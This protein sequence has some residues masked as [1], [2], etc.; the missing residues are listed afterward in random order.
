MSSASTDG[1]LYLVGF[2]FEPDIYDPQLY[3]IYVHDDR[4]IMREGLPVVF[5]RPDLAAK[6]LAQ[7][8]CGA[9][10]LGEAP[11]ELYTVLT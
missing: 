4:P 11:A 1:P 6:A 7:T 8:D 5:P 2:R 10:D 9:V 3:T